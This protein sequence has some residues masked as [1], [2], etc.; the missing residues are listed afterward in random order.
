METIGGISIGNV[1][2]PKRLI[3]DS[4][5]AFQCLV[6]LQL[7]GG[8]LET[9]HYVANKD[10]HV[11]TGQYVYQQIVSGE[12]G[13]IVDFV[14]PTPSEETLADGVRHQR[15][16]ILVQLDAVVT[17][18]LRWSEYSDEQKA[19]IAKYRQDL[20]DITDQPNFPTEITWPTSPIG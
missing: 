1:R 2:E 20:L 11:E 10:D 17:N 18:P 19:A 9:V 13:E 15:K 14:I 6:D 5:Q 3:P 8:Q 12:A 16:M 4:D 7:P